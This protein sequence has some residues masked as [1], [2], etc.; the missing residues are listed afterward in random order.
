LHRHRVNIN[1]LLR[2]IR[3]LLTGENIK[4]SDTVG[5]FANSKSIQL[6]TLSQPSYSEQR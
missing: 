2:E 1:T 5:R 3:Y 6:L 4:S